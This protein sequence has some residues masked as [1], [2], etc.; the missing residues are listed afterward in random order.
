MRKKGALKRLLLVIG[1]S[2]SP[3]FIGVFCVANL[4]NV[5]PFLLSRYH[6]SSSSFFFSSSSTFSTFLSFFPFS[7]SCSNLVYAPHSAKTA[8]RGASPSLLPPPS[9]SCFLFLL[10][11]RS[12]RDRARAR[13]WLRGKRRRKTERVG[14]DFNDA[15]TTLAVI[16]NSPRG[17]NNIYALRFLRF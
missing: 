7:L 14:I 4:A 5:A 2:P 12:R 6:P 9:F 8:G 1:T 16:P 17:A 13:G 11:P 10:S 15:P 3:L